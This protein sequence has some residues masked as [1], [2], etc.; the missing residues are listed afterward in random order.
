M[1]ISDYMNEKRHPNLESLEK[2]ALA[3]LWEPYELIKKDL[4]SSFNPYDKEE[5]YKVFESAVMTTRRQSL[6]K[7]LSLIKADE[8]EDIVH[9]F[10][11]WDLIFGFLKEELEL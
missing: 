1:I 6:F 10:G 8:L 2:L 5:V 7:N 4:P 9:R 11:G 3:L